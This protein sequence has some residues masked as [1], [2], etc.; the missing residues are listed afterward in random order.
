ME[1]EE[2]DEVVKLKKSPF[3]WKDNYIIGSPT[4]VKWNAFGRR[5]SDFTVLIYKVSS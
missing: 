3:R 5:K 4:L 1:A 2:K